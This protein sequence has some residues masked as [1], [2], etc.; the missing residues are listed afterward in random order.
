MGRAAS[1]GSPYPLGANICPGGANF[2]VFSDHADAVELCLFDSPV[3]VAPTEV[4]PLPCQTDGVF[5]GQFAGIEAGQ[6][7]G[8]RAHGPWAPEEGHRFDPCKILLDPYVR[9]IARRPKWGAEVYSFKADHYPDSKELHQPP[10]NLDSADC[11]PLGIVVDTPPPVSSASRPA[12]CWRDTLIYELHVRG[13]TKLHPEVDPS[14]RGTY[15][16]L[17]SE[18]VLDYLRGLGVS[19]VELLPVQHFIDDHRLIDLGL[20]NYW[21]YQPLGY[22]A[23]EPRYAA[24]SGAA[25]PQEFR[26]MVRKFHQAGI[27]VILDVVFNHT[28]EMGHDGPTLSFRGIDNSSYYR[29]DSADKRRYVNFTGCGNTLNTQHPAVVR[30]V[31]DS[32]RYWVEA[33]GV[34][35]FRFD[36]ATTI[37]RTEDGF[38][39]CAP[40]LTA[41]GQDPIL[42]SVKLIAEP[43]DVNSRDSMQLGNFPAHWG[44]WNRHFRD[45]ARRFWRGDARMAPALA[46]R[47]AGSS[48]IFGPRRRR[49]QS[50][51]NFVTSHDGFTLAD[52]VA[53]TRK[54]NIANAESNRDG[55][56]NNHS[57]NCGI[58]GPTQDSKILALRQ[59]QQRNL[60]ATLLLSQGVP[61]LVAGDEFGRTQ[62]GNNNA[63]CQD[64]PISWVDWTQAKGNSLL[65]FV[66]RLAQIRR[67]EPALRREQFFQGLAGAGGGFKD[68]AWLLPNGAEIAVEDWRDDSLQCFGA[69]ISVGNGGVLLLLFN[70]SAQQLAFCLPELAGWRVEFDTAED[71]CAGIALDGREYEL[72]DRS[73]A[74][75]R[76]DGG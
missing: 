44:E 74:L 66:R 28:A 39:R 11:S 21:G 10:S 63:Y 53:Y 14:L 48:D 26:D 41:I 20:A 65:D 57:W 50:S 25:V 5:H 68:V 70:S 12:T 54:R 4:L 7:Y 40:L 24:T 60:L 9:A 32:L 62:G 73:F 38:D 18:P 42:Q 72:A 43:W 69:L 2:A 8:Y 46:S 16:G 22:F 30:L 29:L 56:L 52:L 64:N 37:G 19:A 45:D 47:I 31:L 76:A 34:D 75:L 61:M 59:R 15:A 35:G 27:E 17:A 49:P 51:I 13:F 71:R 55:E 36:L 67:G 1:R 58:D 33:I 6:I 3:E 23:P